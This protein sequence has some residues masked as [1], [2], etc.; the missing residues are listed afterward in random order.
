M[1]YTSNEYS[2]VMETSSLAAAVT[3]GG[4]ASSESSVK[5]LISE[6]AVRN[7]YVSI[8]TVGFFGNLIIFVVMTFYTNVKEKVCTAI[9]C[10]ACKLMH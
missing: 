10:R 4:K 1:E 7:I 5:V 9:V 6:E 3:E 8:G 2:N